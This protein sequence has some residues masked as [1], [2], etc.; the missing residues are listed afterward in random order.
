MP[1]CRAG[2][3]L[4]E[5]QVSWCRKSL[6]VTTAALV[7]S[8]TILCCPGLLLGLLAGFVLVCLLPGLALTHL[9]RENLGSLDVIEQIIISIGTGY[10]LLIIVALALEYLPLHF[11]RGNILLACNL[12]IFALLGL[13]F[14]SRENGEKLT[15]ISRRT[16]YVCLLTAA[17]ASALRFPSLD[18]SDFVGDEAKALLWAAE[19]AQGHG[20]VIFL[21]RK[22]LAEIV[23]SAVF[24]A[25][26]GRTNSLPGC[27]SPSQPGRDADH[28]PVGTLHVQRVG[29]VGC[30]T[31]GQH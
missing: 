21:Y 3:L 30:R 29:W 4:R 26:L 9:L 12:V 22:R 2:Q 14:W 16:V 24:Q 23:I 5:V 28:F 1:G 25:L 27:P 10:V 11:S 17:A 6:I 31:S 13:R 15:T 20:N 18:H 19:V 8:L 7:S